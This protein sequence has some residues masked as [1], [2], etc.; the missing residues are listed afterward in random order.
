MTTLLKDIV[1]GM[2]PP[3][4]M[5]IE[6]ETAWMIIIPI[7]LIIVLIVGTIIFIAKK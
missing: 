5:I 6:Q 7:V 2:G 3:E 1:G 4:S